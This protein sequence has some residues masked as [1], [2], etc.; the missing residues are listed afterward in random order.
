MGMDGM[1]TRRPGVPE[2]VAAKPISRIKAICG[3][4]IAEKRKEQDGRMQARIMKKEFDLRVS[5]YAA[6]WGENIVIRIQHRQGAVV[7]VNKIGFSPA[8]LSKYM[9]MLDHPSGI[10]LVTG[11][12]G[13]GKSTTL[14]ASLQYPNKSNKVIRYG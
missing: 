9:K 12:T 3:L 5:T 2:Y 1:R 6:I 14:Y 7:D 4:D 13:S 11:P 10:I 8:N